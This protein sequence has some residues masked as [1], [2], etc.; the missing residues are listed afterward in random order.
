VFAIQIGNKL[1]AACAHADLR[2]ER[3]DFGCGL[4]LILIPKLP[5]GVH[6]D[7]KLPA[8]LSAAVDELN[9]GLNV[10]FAACSGC[11]G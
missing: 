6:E 9:G 4:R 10:G 8:N 11:R 3:V 2:L 1:P 7:R 5:A